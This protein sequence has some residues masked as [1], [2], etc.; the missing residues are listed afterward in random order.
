MATLAASLTLNGLGSVV[1]SL[2]TATSTQT[3]IEATLTTIAGGGALNILNNRNYAIGVAS[4]TDNGKIVLGGG[5]ISG[6]ALTI[7]ATGV[8]S[9]FGT[10]TGATNNG[11]LD[12]SG[13]D[14]KIT[15]PI[16]GSGKLEIESASEL[17]ISGSTGESLAFEAASGMFR[18]ENATGVSYSGTIS[19]L[20]TGDIL[21]LGNT[22]ATTATAG[23][24][25][26]TTTALTVHLSGGGSLTY[27]LAGDYSKDSFAVSHVNGNADSDISVVASSPIVSWI[28]GSADWN[29][30]ADWSSGVVPNSASDA[31]VL[32][33]SSAYTVSIKAG[34]SF[35]VGS[36]LI[37]DP[38]AA[39][40]L[41][42]PALTVTGTI[43]DSGT[44]D[45]TSG[46]TVTAAAVSVSGTLINA[47]TV[48]APIV[49]FGSSSADRLILYPG[50]TFS[51]TVTGGGASTTLELAKGTK[52]G[53]L[54]ALG[55]EFLNFG[56]VVVD[57]GANWTVYTT[58]TA[59]AGTRII[60]SGGPS[61]LKVTTP[62]TFSLGGVSGITT[63]DLAPGNN[64]VTVTDT[65]LSG[66]TVAIHAGASGNNSISAAGDTSASKGKTLSYFPT[67]GTDS[68]IGG[69]END[70]VTATL[71]ELPS[72]TLTGGRGTNTLALTTA[73]AVSYGSNI[74]NFTVLDLSAGNNTVTVTDVMLA[75]GNMLALGKL[76]I[77]D[78]ASGNNSISAAGDTI[79]SKGRT[80]TYYAGKGIDS[81]TGGFENDTVNVSPTAL[82]GDA[83]TGGTGTNTLIMAAAGTVTYGSNVKNFTVLDLAAGNNTVT[84][85]DAMLAPGKLAIH[86]GGSGNN[87]I[88]ASGDTAMS[89]GKTLTYY[90]GKGVDTFTGNFENDTIYISAATLAGDTL[91]GGKGT[92]MLKLTTA[93]AVS[94]GTNVKNFTE[95]DLATGNNTVTLTDAMLLPG[96]LAIHAG[97]SG[98]TT[99][100]SG[101][102]AASKGKTLIYYAGKGIDTFTGG[103]EQDVVTYPLAANSPFVPGQNGAPDDTINAFKAGM[104]LIDL[105]G[106]LLSHKSVVDK[107]VVGSFTDITTK[108]YFGTAGVAVEYG[109]G[110]TARV[111]VDANK[112][113]NLDSGDML[114]KFTGVAAHALGSSSFEM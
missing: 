97:A 91:T 40:T 36:V 104:D 61:V 87:S 39:L 55:T 106:I 85:T 43:T 35:T 29:T 105:R 51:G 3:P 111:F 70:K 12:A 26:G 25:N 15:T 9:G 42:G 90:A 63:I 110:N 22:N 6:G 109:A 1:E 17:A 68:F 44:V 112:D 93:G 92:D 2:N 107:G 14:L 4:L 28:G 38:A 114:I 98:T 50:A 5:A 79:A 57:P 19:G 66:G 102:T 20:V 84:V 10:V 67:T 30:P 58:E 53:T 34:E 24:F 101:E 108:G 103:F 81:F 21:E 86:A 73:G 46:G 94:Y 80:L 48:S 47:G 65:T 76:A 82:A 77:H 11:I 31:V 8:L 72:L 74:Q 89:S 49:A 16:T 99:V 113:G 32:P 75:E 71:A 60:G 18:I 13:G 88:S 64:V 62:G 59:L 56:T 52:A 69:F 100:I 96:T 83:L 41:T 23:A 37:S 7:G 45:V 33:G 27:N 95:L 54:N 78:G